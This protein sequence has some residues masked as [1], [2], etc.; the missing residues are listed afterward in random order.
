MGEIKWTFDKTI[1]ELQVTKNSIAVEAKVRPASISDMEKG[2]PT[3]VEFKTIAA[4]LDVLN[5]MGKE[6]GINRKFTIKDLF[7]YEDTSDTSEK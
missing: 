6:K 5:K 3:R 1:E 4:I 7:I 2:I